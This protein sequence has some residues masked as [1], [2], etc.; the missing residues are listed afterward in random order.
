MIYFVRKIIIAVIQWQARVVLW[1]YKPRIIA[2]TGSIGKTG[3]KDAIFTVMSHM[4]HARRSRKSFNSDIGIPLTIIGVPTGWRDILKWIRNVFKGFWVMLA[5]WYSYPDWLVL[6]VGIGK[7]GDMQELQKWVRPDIVVV[8]AFGSVPSH[9]EFFHSREAVWQEESQILNVLSPD[10]LLVLN[11]DDEHVYALR[12]RG[13]EQVITYGFHDDADVRI[14]D[15]RIT[16]LDEKPVGIAFSLQYQQETVEVALEGILGKSVAYYVAAASAVAVTQH[17][18]L[19]SFARILST[20]AVPRGRLT[21]I[22]GKNDSVIIDD[23]YNASPTAVDNALDVFESI[24]TRG[25]K[26]FAFGDMLELGKFSAKEHE[27]IG[28]SAVKVCDII[29]T[30]G[31]RAERAGIVAHE[32]GMSA[33][34]IYHFENSHDAGVFL[35]D[36]ITKDDIILVK[37]SQGV[38]MER[39][40]KALMAEPDRA[41]EFLVRQEEAWLKK[42]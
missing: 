32:S 40:S 21:L 13:T 36:F 29:V 42:E 16:S 28:I 41:G 18:T 34:R 1:R 4:V 33:E 15:Y 31:P 12:H 7:P 11:R 9:V 14:L 19:E 25:R 2:I 35:A 10:G 30:V 37:G 38:R 24:T 39:I 22:S 3:T 23:S 6:E 20:I 8:S 27:N 26:I 17:Y 5:P